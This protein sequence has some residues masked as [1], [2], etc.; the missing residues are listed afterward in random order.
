MFGV[1]KIVVDAAAFTD[2]KAVHAALKEAIGSE[3]YIGSNLDALHDVLT[4]ICKKTRITVKN[5]HKA[6]EQLE[7]YAKSLASVLAASAA[8]N[9]YLTVVFE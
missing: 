4:T 8:E 1:R 6:E 9:P 7:D 5:F 2:K 3:D